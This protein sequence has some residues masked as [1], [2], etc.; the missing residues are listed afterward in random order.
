MNET[1]AIKKGLVYGTRGRKLPCCPKIDEIARGSGG[2]EGRGIAF[3]PKV[4]M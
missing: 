4:R 3:Y 2:K 1:N